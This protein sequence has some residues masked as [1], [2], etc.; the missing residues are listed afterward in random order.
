[1][2]Q[3]LILDYIPTDLNTYINKER[4]NRYMA[5][6]IKKDET[7]K[8][9]WKCKEQALKSIKKPVQINCYWYIKNKKKDPDNLSFSKKFLLDGLVKA[10][11]LAND[12]LNNIVGFEDH[13]IIDTDEQVIVDLIEI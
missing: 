9:Y 4:T 10:G 13:F 1:M 11:V 3:T 12:G 7:N 2:K 8:A 5:A 6:Q